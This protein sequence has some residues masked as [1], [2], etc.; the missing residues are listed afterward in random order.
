MEAW[1]I[2]SSIGTSPAVTM[3]N[4]KNLSPHWH[5]GFYRAILFPRESPAMAMDTG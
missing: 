2:V 1:S 5:S 3:G 4:H